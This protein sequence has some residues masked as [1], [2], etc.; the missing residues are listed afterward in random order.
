HYIDFLGR[1]PDSFGF[2]GWQDI[3]NNCGAGDTKCDRIE[4]SA[5]FFRS[6]EFQER[7]YFTYRFYSVALGRKPDYVEFLPDLAKVSGFLTD[8]E[9]EA[10]KVAFVDEFMARATFK[11]KYDSTV[12]NPAAYVD[13]LLTT[14]GL[15]TH[16]SRAGWIAGL[17]NGQITRGQVLRQLAESQQAYDKFYTEAFVVMQYFGYL[18]RD[19]DKFY[20]DWIAIMNQNPANYRNMVNGF[21]NST[22]YRLRFGP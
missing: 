12:N 5:G 17:T 7:G 18:R 8:A 20:L 6:P 3:L 2:K 21:M 13:A 15:P 9:K 19:P 22:E 10:N 11:N 16:P 4:V 14:A 1:E